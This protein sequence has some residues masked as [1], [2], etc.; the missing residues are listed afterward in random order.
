[1]SEKMLKCPKKCPKKLSLFFESPIRESMFIEEDI[2]KELNERQKTAIEYINKNKSISRQN[3]M[4]ITAVSH[5]T[6][7]KEL[8]DM[9]KKRILIEEGAG[10]YRRYRLTRRRI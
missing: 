5:T 3:Y 8:K 1:M 6:A 10:K 2:L 4:K 7:H 9:V